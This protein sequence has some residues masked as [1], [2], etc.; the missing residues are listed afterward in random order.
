MKYPRRWSWM[1]SPFLI[2]AMAGSPNISVSCYETEKEKVERYSA[3]TTQNRAN[4]GNSRAKTLLQSSDWK[5]WKTKRK[6]HVKNVK[7]YRYIYSSISLVSHLGILVNV[8]LEVIILRE[9]GLRNDVIKLDRDCWKQRC[10]GG[11]C[12]PCQLGGFLE[13]LREKT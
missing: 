12:Y 13:I 7:F 9:Y 4:F 11:L 6:F 3:R 5:V 10:F 8:V 1:M 2:E